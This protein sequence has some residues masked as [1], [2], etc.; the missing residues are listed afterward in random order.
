M[1]G[2][3]GW[4]NDPRLFKHSKWFG[5][6]TFTH[7]CVNLKHTLMHISNI[8]WCT[9]VS[10]FFWGGYWGLWENPRAGALY[11]RVLFHFY[12]QIF[13]CILLGYMRCPLPPPRPPICAFILGP[14][15]KDYFVCFFLINFKI[16]TKKLFF[17]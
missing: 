2:C 7:I 3:D 14:S 8:D 16:K 11:F 4:W 9:V 6:R 17:S 12:D 1:V 15:S 10:K 5:L 13:W